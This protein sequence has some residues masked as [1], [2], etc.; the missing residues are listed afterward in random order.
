MGGLIW[1]RV[2]AL[3]WFDERYAIYDLVYIF[4]LTSTVPLF[5]SGSMLYL[6]SFFFKAKVTEWKYKQFLSGHGT[7]SKCWSWR[8]PDMMLH[9]AARA[10]TTLST[11]LAGE[12]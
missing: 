12:H 7:C 5:K 2:M 8:S 9:R 10:A 6:F 1:N 11:L 3:L 4:S